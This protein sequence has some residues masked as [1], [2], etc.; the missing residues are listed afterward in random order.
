M[1]V[2]QQSEVR[3]G[4]ERR[5]GPDPYPK[6]EEKYP[7]EEVDSDPYTKK[8]EKLDTK[9]FMWTETKDVYKDL[10][11]REGV[12]GYKNGIESIAVIFNTQMGRE[13]VDQD[14]Y[15]NQLPEEAG[16]GNIVTIAPTKADYRKYSAFHKKTGNL[17]FLKFEVET[18]NF[19]GWGEN[20]VFM[21]DKYG[22]QNSEM[23]TADSS[24]KDLYYYK[25]LSYFDWTIDPLP[26]WDITKYVTV[27]G[28]YF[29]QDYSKFRS[30]STF[31]IKVNY[32]LLEQNAYDYATRYFT[33]LN[34]TM[35]DVGYVKFYVC[36][37]RYDS[38]KDDA[39]YQD[40]YAV[41]IE[42]QLS[43]LD[44]EREW[45]ED[46]IKSFN[47]GYAVYDEQYLLDLA[48]YEED[49][50]EQIEYRMAKSESSRMSD[51][52]VY[53]A[54]DFHKE[55]REKTLNQC[56]DLV[57]YDDYDGSQTYTYEFTDKY[58]YYIEKYFEYV[59][60]EIRD[61]ER[62]AESVQ[63]EIKEKGQEARIVSSDNSMSNNFAC[64]EQ[65]I[66]D[67]Y[68][69]KSFCNFWANMI[70]MQINDNYKQEIHVA[71]NKADEIK[72]FEFEGSTLSFSR[73]MNTSMLKEVWVQ[74]TG[75]AQK[76]D[77]EVIYQA[78]FTAEPKI[79]E[80]KEIWLVQ[81]A[82]TLPKDEDPYASKDSSYGDDK[83]A[84]KYADK[85]SKYDTKDTSSKDYDTKYEKTDD[86]HRLLSLSEEQE[87]LLEA[88]TIEIDAPKKKSMLVKFID[89]AS[90]IGCAWFVISS[91]IAPF[92][93]K[94][95]SKDGYVAETTTK[96]IYHRIEKENHEIQQNEIELS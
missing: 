43:E 52:K 3:V 7:A 91:I 51:N 82:S 18:Y 27:L 67:M 90:Y 30:Y 83:Y 46:K 28:D 33:D 96:Q 86:G 24:V 6:E 16:R 12:T 79:R 64:P 21:T 88:T 57:Y 35:A 23:K 66:A 75:Y 54:E 87:D 39:W 14:F 73:A 65:V 17:R 58:D 62:F 41:T 59:R 76:M 93:E 68:K 34:F 61:Y 38:L 44:D 25:P 71:P 78:T 80:N 4:G 50:R 13:G 94:L 63:I 11:G 53:I 32:E 49:L 72:M 85:D 81:D 84:D 60:G 1:L 19:R 29:D 26:K 9:N 55:I 89:L 37:D 8:E 77:W 5:L 2:S 69:G 40:K 31:R 74:Y 95:I 10:T 56:F 48:E 20:E 45:F 42:D 47:K 22:N 36:D 70:Y 92:I 15:L